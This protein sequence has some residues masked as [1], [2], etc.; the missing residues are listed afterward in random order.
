MDVDQM[1]EEG[2]GG[3]CNNGPM[4]GVSRRV[5]REWYA[6]EGRREKMNSTTRKS[7]ARPE[8]IKA[9]GRIEG[10]AGV[11]S[12]GKGKEGWTERR[13]RNSLFMKGR[14]AGSDRDSLS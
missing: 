14:Q 3:R 4:V 6:R 2:V 7:A 5:S 11:E 13:G 9:Q 1:G 12:P 8:G 10:E